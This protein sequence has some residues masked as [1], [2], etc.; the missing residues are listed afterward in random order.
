MAEAGFEVVKVEAAAEF[1]HGSQFHALLK[2]V[3]YLERVLAT[4]IQHGTPE[5]A[6]SPI[7]G[8]P[9]EFV[10]NFIEKLTPASKDTIYTHITSL[11][12]RDDLGEGG[13]GIVDHIISSPSK[14]EKVVQI[15]S[16]LDDSENTMQC[17]QW[18]ED[19]KKRPE[20][21]K[22]ALESWIS[23][24]SKVVG[25]VIGDK[26]LEHL[27]DMLQ[28]EVEEK[29]SVPEPGEEQVKDPE[30]GAS[31]ETSDDVKSKKIVYNNAVHRL[32]HLLF[33][34]REYTAVVQGAEGEKRGDVKV[35]ENNLVG[36]I[37][38]SYLIQLMKRFFQE[39]EEKDE[40]SQE[41]V[42]YINRMLSSLVYNSL[43]ND[44]EQGAVRAAEFLNVLGEE[45]LIKDVMKYIPH[46]DAG[47]MGKYVK[48][49]ERMVTRLDLTMVKPMASDEM[50]KDMS[51][52]FKMRKDLC[53]KQWGKDSDAYKATESV[54]EEHA[55]LMKMIRRNY[56]DRK[57]YLN[58]E[59]EKEKDA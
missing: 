45:Y 58:E 13:E 38:Y 19:C 25:I 3:E 52:Y 47:T 35:L 42:I 34:S 26:M 28:E 44:P 49:F 29:E 1:E 36:S 56:A 20:L 51:T 40:F 59:T 32:M 30:E 2:R 39:A 54:A 43:I 15:G 12:G 10:D 7:P 37:G 9:A 17:E 57:D 5:M 16:K 41:D 23:P 48:G 21:F 8:M 46:A 18:F 50:K 33:S 24:E 53:E 4:V 14:N 27:V 31:K 6:L 22:K 55:R 11:I